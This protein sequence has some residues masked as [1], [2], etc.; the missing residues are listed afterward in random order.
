[1]RSRR[2]VRQLVRRPLVALLPGGL[3]GATPTA[4]T[5]A[6]LRTSNQLVIAAHSLLTLYDGRPQQACKIR[7]HDDVTTLLGGWIVAIVRN[8]RR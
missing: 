8:W 3:F 6:I 2:G 7:R 1:M 4:T 5:L